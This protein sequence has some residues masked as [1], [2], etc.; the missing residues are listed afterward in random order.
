M[1]LPPTSGYTAPGSDGRATVANAQNKAGGV[2]TLINSLRAVYV[3]QY[4][5][6]DDTGHVAVVS[7]RGAGA[8]NWVTYT[9]AGRVID[10][11]RSRRTSL[12]EDRQISTI[13]ITP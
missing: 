1:F 4:G 2:A 6:G 3:A 8:E 13:A 11:M 7:D 9:E 10:T 12:V 5:P